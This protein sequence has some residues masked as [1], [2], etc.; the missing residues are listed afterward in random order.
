MLG[1]QT[2]NTKPTLHHW[3]KSTHK[4]SHGVFFG[5]HSQVP[6]EMCNFQT[7]A[8]ACSFPCSKSAPGNASR[9]QQEHLLVT[10]RTKGATVLF[11]NSMECM[12]FGYYYVS[13]HY[14]DTYSISSIHCILL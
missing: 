3:V 13:S 14:A 9:I 1:L 8:V 5:G 11:S 12:A 4:K 7:V 2:T 6:S 10:Q